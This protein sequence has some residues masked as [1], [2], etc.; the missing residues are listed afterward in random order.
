MFGS[1]QKID[2][3]KT[4]RLTNKTLSNLIN[5]KI[6]TKIKIKEKHILL[7]TSP[8]IRETIKITKAGIM[9]ADSFTQDLFTNNKNIARK[10]INH[11]DSKEVQKTKREYFK[12]T[13]NT[14]I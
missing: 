8:V 11:K 12:L 9:T 2:K 13:I 1:K 5:T 4:K 7:D 10:F 3:I 6:E 14:S